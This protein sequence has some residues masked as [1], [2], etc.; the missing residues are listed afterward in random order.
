MKNKQTTYLKSAEVDTLVNFSIMMGNLSEE[1]KFE[2]M[3]Q[4]MSFVK[5]GDK[6]LLTK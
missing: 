2:K 1:G 3:E 4:I 6:S 5:T